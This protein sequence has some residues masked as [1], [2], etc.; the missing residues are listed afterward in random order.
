MKEFIDPAVVVLDLEQAKFGGPTLR[1]KDLRKAL[2]DFYELLTTQ[3]DE[4]IR[5]WAKYHE[6]P[7]REFHESDCTHSDCRPIASG[8]DSDDSDS[9]SESGT[10]RDANG[11][12]ICPECIQKVQEFN[13]RH[14]NCSH[15][16]VDLCPKCNGQGGE[17][18]MGL[19]DDNCTCEEGD[20]HYAEFI[21]TEARYQDAHG[22]DTEEE[23]NARL[24]EL[25]LNPDAE[26]YAGEREMVILHSSS[27]N[28]FL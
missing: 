26:E 28:N 15:S 1:I 10:P 8:E 18:D 23:V 24:D 6:R 17:Q 25:R 16:S 3:K 20:R 22:N 9:A 2:T 7:E 27:F 12:C 19:T 21:A 14:R 11:D 13:Y 5:A 4:A